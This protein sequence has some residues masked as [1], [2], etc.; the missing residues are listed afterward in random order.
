MAVLLVP[1]AALQP[2]A[3][4]AHTHITNVLHVKTY[5]FLKVQMKWLRNFPLKFKRPRCGGSRCRERLHLNFTLA[6][7]EVQIYM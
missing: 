2:G 1:C 5:L 7:T 6:W 3:W 4:L